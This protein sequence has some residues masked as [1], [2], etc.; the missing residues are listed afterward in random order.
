V[1]ILHYLNFF[2]SVLKKSLIAK[3]I[4]SIL[5]F[6][7]KYILLNFYEDYYQ[8]NIGDKLNYYIAIKIFKKI[9][10]NYRYC[11]NP[12]S[13]P[14]Y[15]FIGSVLDNYTNDNLIVWGSGFMA[16]D[17]KVP[18][19]AIVHCLRGKLSRNKFYNNLYYPNPILMDPAILLPRLY[20][21]PMKKIYLIGIVPHFTEVNRARK[22]IKEYS[23]FSSKITIIDTNTDKIESFIDQLNSC[24]KIVSTSLHGLVLSDAYKIPNKWIKL[25]NEVSGGGEFKFLDYYSVYKNPDDK[26]T[27]VLSIDEILSL[28]FSIH[29]NQE[30][31]YE[32]I[33]KDL[34]LIF[35]E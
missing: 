3:L 18:K 20:N 30:I 12:L 24:E 6:N 35:N 29:I 14:V 7:K 4:N 32:K 9:P 1:K 19:N 16:P 17:S 26:P 22:L 31:D 13:K 11:F 8:K 28:N 10:I 21:K 5:L 15:S 34:P 33:L 27:L 25:S 23:N 2:L